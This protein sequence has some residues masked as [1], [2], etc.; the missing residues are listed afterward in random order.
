M[1]KTF[2]HMNII[3]LAGR[4][5]RV[6]TL[7]LLLTTLTGW[8]FSLTAQQPVSVKSSISPVNTTDRLAAIENAVEKRRR[9]LG[10][11]GLSLAI[12]KDGEVILSKGFGSRNLGKNL[13][14]TPET[15]FAIGSTTKAFT[16]MTTVMSA[17]SGKLSLDDSPKNFLP[18]FKLRDPE[19]DAQATLRDLLTHR[20]GL[21]RTDFLLQF[22]GSLTRE[23]IIRIAGTARPTA[24]LRERFQYQNVMFVAAGE[25]AAKANGM[26]WEKLVETSIFK[27]LAMNKTTISIA[28]M[29]KSKDFSLGYEYDAETKETK[30]LKMIDLAKIAPAGAINSNAKDMAQWLKFLLG[31]G[32]YNGKRLVSEKNF[33]ELFTRQ[34]Q[35]APNVGYGLGWFIREWD[36]KKAIEHAGNIDGFNAVVMML[37]EEKI[38]LV[39]LTNVTASPLTSEIREIV[40]SNLLEQPENKTEA[41][42]NSSNSNPVINT[43][44]ATIENSPV[45]REIL[46]NYETEAKGTPIDI[47]AGDNAVFFV[48][49][50]QPPR[51]LIEKATDVFAVEGLPEIYNLTIKRDADGKIANLLF[52]QR[53]A[54]AILR[55]VKLPPNAPTVDELMKRVIEAAGG[56]TNLRKHFSMRM[57]AAVNLE[58]EGITSEVTVNAKAPNLTASTVKYFALGKQIGEDFDYFDGSNGGSYTMDNKAIVGTPRRKSGKFLEDARI[59][60]DFYAPLNWKTLYKTVEL[61]KTS[62]IAGE[63]VYV[64]IKTPANGNPVTDYISQKTFLVLRRETAQSGGGQSVPYIDNFSDFRMVDGVM[65]PFKIMSGMANSRTVST[66]VQSIEFNVNA[67]DSIFRP[68]PLVKSS[69]RK[70]I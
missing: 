30:N 35:I 64:I 3:S 68:S 32:V 33:A 44:F 39:L 25:A 63:D 50:G 55:N 67:P 69:R 1:L 66:N 16:A 41:N 38:G 48:L 29:Q 37:P 65:L 28:E 51:R 21:D 23:E 34:I 4:K 49:Q 57:R 31:S 45:L 59:E 10:I 24:K 17:D 22:S 47:I 2:I 36:G 26:T 56:E 58:Y 12:V 8:S 62:R 70:T 27:P 11:P 14:V 53:D 13:P 6:L 15:L 9:E 42:A 60:A 61:K 54:A 40:F 20:V 46:G 52:N 7:F 5:T 19:A 18:F 43:N